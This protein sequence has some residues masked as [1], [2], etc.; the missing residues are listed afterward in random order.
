MHVSSGTDETHKP[1]PLNIIKS[2][3]IPYKRTHLKH[4]LFEYNYIIIYLVSLFVSSYIARNITVFLFLIILVL[5]ASAILV[6][7]FLK[8]IS[9]LIASA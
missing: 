4:L 8:G 6:I 9:V 3:Y 2:R 1:T 7:S 5:V